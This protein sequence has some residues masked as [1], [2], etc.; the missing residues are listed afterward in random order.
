MTNS[1]LSEAEL[2]QEEVAS[3][4]RAQ[5]ALQDSGYFRRW[6]GP[7]GAVPV[8]FLAE[9][10]SGE[11]VYF[12][13]RGKKL[14]MQIAATAADWQ[15]SRYL[16]SFEEPYRHAQDTLGAGLCPADHCTTQILAWLKLY[17]QARRT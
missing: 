4:A 11:F 1:A 7:F 13:A 12:R 10:T 14:S 17:Q 6:Q 3:R 9:L 15:E 8:Q 16:A 5:T 2:E